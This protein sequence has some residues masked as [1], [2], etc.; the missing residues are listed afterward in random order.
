MPITCL[1]E[2]TRMIKFCITQLFK[3]LGLYFGKK[4]KEVVN[5]LFLC[6]PVSASFPSVRTC[7][8]WMLGKALCSQRYPGVVS[9]RQSFYSVLNLGKLSLSKSWVTDLFIATFYYHSKLFKNFFPVL[10]FPLKKSH[11]FSLLLSFHYLHFYF[12][13]KYFCL[14]L[15]VSH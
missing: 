13:F 5:P 1:G 15:L 11:G 4:K 3:Q 10:D 14:C 6:Y 8:M 12:V 9:L 2:N 7:V